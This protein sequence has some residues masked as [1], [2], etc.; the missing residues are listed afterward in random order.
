MK[1]FWSFN[2]YLLVIM[3]LLLTSCCDK[4]GIRVMDA[5]DSLALKASQTSNKTVPA[6]Q[7]KA[8]VELKV[9]AISRSPELFPDRH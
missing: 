8:P 9:A 7:K 4:R 1:N 6:E 2:F 3:C 5:S